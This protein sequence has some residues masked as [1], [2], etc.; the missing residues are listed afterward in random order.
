MLARIRWL[1]GAGFLWWMMEARGR[2]GRWLLEDG[3]GGSA[4]GCGPDGCGYFGGSGW[5]KGRTG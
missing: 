5:G 2:G 3:T 4:L 1:D